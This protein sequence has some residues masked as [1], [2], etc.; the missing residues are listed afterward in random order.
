MRFRFSAL[1]TNWA[2]SRILSTESSR[3]QR[4]NTRNT[5]TD[6]ERSCDFQLNQFLTNIDKFELIDDDILPII[7]LMITNCI[8]IGIVIFFQYPSLIA[9]VIYNVRTS[10]S[11]KNQ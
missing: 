1:E 3:L 2:I 6:I 11:V 8:C 10:L 7:F 5:A 9:D 4:I